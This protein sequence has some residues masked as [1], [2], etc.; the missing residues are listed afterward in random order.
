M[1]DRNEVLRNYGNLIASVWEDEQV[2]DELQAEPKKVL[3]N[4]GFNISDD[5]EVN[6]ILREINTDGTPSTQV[7]MYIKGQETGV[8]DIIVPL[9]PSDEVLE[10][11]P[12]Q[13]D[14]LEL[15]AGGV[16]ACCCCCPC[17]DSAD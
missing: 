3:N 12:L 17:C 9:R 8:Y 5:S 6:L 1:T 7:D 4:F 2:L 10:D 11:L 15:V 14:M 16:V 13:D